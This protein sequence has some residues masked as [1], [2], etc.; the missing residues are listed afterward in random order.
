MDSAP[1]L[2]FFAGGP[3]DKALRPVTGLMFSLSGAETPLDGVGKN[4]LSISERELMLELGEGG[5]HV[6]SRKTTNV[7]SVA[8]DMV[9]YNRSNSRCEESIGCTRN[10]V[11]AACRRCGGGKVVDLDKSRIGGSGSAK[12]NFIETRSGTRP[13]NSACLIG[14]RR[15]Q[16]AC[17]EAFQPNRAGACVKC[18]PGARVAAASRSALL[19][20]AVAP[21]GHRN[22][23]S[24]R[25][26]HC[27]LKTTRSSGQR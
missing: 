25:G 27:Y 20:P 2:R 24:L 13:S 9:L 21:L 1:S 7:R 19:A 6:S 16:R 22:G 14:Y 8:I 26:G 3:S 10:C 18:L 23:L 5:V 15:C 17:L 4:P 11:E 12:F